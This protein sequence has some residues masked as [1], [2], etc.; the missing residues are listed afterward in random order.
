MF[1]VFLFL[2][3]VLAAAVAFYG[4]VPF[5]PQRETFVTIAPGTSSAGLAAEL[6]RAG[7]VRSRYA[8]EALRLWRE[9]TGSAGTLKAGEYR[10]DHVAPVTEIYDRLRRGDVYSL[11]VVVPEGFNIFDVAD[12]VA[13]AGLLK[14]A[15]DPQ[16]EFLRAEMEH[17][18][19]VRAWSPQ[20]RSVEG[21][22]FPDTYRFGRHATAVQMLTAMTRRFGVEAARL[23]LVAPGEAG[24]STPRSAQADPLRGG[25]ERTVTIAS[26]VEKEVHVDAERPEVASV[27]ENRLT[28]GMPLQTDPAVIYASLLRGTWTGVIHQ[29]ELH[30]D[31]AYNTYA[32]VGLPP[33]PICN[34]GLASLR[35]AMHP[36]QTDFYYFVADARGATRFSATLAEH[37][38]KVQEYRRAAGSQ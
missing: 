33:G 26:L 4:L 21:F 20:A 38:A 35:A 9:A 10:F 19:L 34:P 5:G 3:V 23:G 25:V 18:E 7:V 6:E 36:A 17:V 2:S 27:F 31:S 16:A 12:A 24:T 30:S 37:T 13:G 32:H 8:F 11:T 28:A 15:A 1:R 29:S 14:D 22:L